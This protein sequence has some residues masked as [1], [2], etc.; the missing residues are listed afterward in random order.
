MRIVFAEPARPKSGT[1]VVG[2]LED[3]KLSPTAAA[4]DKETRRRHQAGDRRE[5]VYR[6]QGRGAGGAGAA[7]ARRSAACCC[8]AW[9]S[10]Q[11]LDAAALQALGGNI[12][13]QL[14]SVGESEAAVALD[15]LDG[16]ALK[17]VEAAADFAYGARLR[18]YRFDK[19]RTKEKPEQKPSL[20]TLDRAEPRQRR[21]ASAT[22]RR[23]R[24]SPRACS[25]PAISS[26]SRPTSSIPRRW[27]PRRARSTKL[28]VEVE[29]L[30]E[31]QMKKLGMG[32][33]LGVAQGSARPPRLVVMQWK[34]GPKGKGARRSPFSARA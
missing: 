28:G 7:G 19:Y 32:A 14:N 9:A 25:S 6:A 11:A 1:I 27:P 3:R 29:V 23:S 18:S 12:V 8:W 22:S 33:L 17:P 4:L 31:K 10:A 20:K 34:G 16:M 21:R 26:P 2:V 5:P 13:A 24:R 30:D 15:K